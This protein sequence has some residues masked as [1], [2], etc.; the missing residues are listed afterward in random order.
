MVGGQGVE[1]IDE[2]VEVKLA[3]GIGVSGGVCPA[4]LA[5]WSSRGD[6]LARSRH[7]RLEVGDQIQKEELDAVVVREFVE[8][9]EQHANFISR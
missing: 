7:G 9:T 3:A 8:L 5:R 4:W 1:D 2:Q 6:P